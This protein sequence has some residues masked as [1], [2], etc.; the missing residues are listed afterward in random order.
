CTHP[1]LPPL[2]AEPLREN[3][4]SRSYH[5]IEPEEF[6]RY[7]ERAMNCSYAVIRSAKHSRKYRHDLLLK[8]GPHDQ[9]DHQQV[10]KQHGCLADPVGFVALLFREQAACKKCYSHEN[11]HDQI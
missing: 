7:P 1:Q 2:E 8:R 10:Q 6:S 9:C 5:D 3:I 11:L 4:R